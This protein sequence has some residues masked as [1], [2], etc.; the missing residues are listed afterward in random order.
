MDPLIIAVL[1]VAVVVGLI[2]VAMLAAFIK[3][4]IQALASGVHV[5]LFNLVAMKLRRVNPS[6]IVQCRINAFKAGLHID[7]NEMES[8]Y[9]AGGNV[10]R[11]IQ[12]LIAANKANIELSFKRATAIDLAGRDILDAVQTSVN[13]K[14]I[15]CPD[16]TKGQPTVAAVAMDGIQLRAKARVTVRTN[17]N[18]LVGGA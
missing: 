8:H 11:V 14:V 9:L 2:L 10:V 6:I 1:A 13:P 17:I 5:S 15:D 4:Y 18:T 3:L 12:A 7:G 16:P